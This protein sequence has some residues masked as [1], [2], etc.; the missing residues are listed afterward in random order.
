MRYIVSIIVCLILASCFSEN[1]DE[2]WSG[3]ERKEF[4]TNKLNREVPIGSRTEKVKTWIAINSIGY[5]HYKERHEYHAQLEYKKFTGFSAF[6]CN[7]WGIYLTISMD[8]NGRS[9]KNEVFG[10]GTCL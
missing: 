8:E 1:P 5:S 7:D 10:G 4:W 9:V 3:K 2:N 6:P